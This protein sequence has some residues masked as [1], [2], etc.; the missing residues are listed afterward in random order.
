MSVKKFIVKRVDRQDIKTFIE[1]WHY[2]KTI[3]GCIADYCYGLFNENI[4]IGAMFFGRMAMK[5]Q[6]KRFS[7]DEKNVIELRRLCCVDETP[8]NTESFFIGKALKLLRNDWKKGI[9]VSYADMDY[10]HNGT[11]YKASNF[12]EIEQT[13]KGKIIVFNGKLYHDKSLRTKYNGQLK[14]FAKKLIDAIKSGDAFYRNTL[15]K[16]TFIYYL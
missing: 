2:S 13:K 16:K 6:Y 4:L 15:G 14:P 8:K 12:I 7:D 1:K 11:I 9:V 3:N 10:G 5:N